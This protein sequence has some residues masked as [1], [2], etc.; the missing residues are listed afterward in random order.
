MV[1]ISHK[2]LVILTVLYI[3]NI[4]GSYLVFIN[5]FGEGFQISEFFGLTSTQHLK[6]RDSNL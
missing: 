2:T 1:Q 6:T 4:L 5:V 3:H